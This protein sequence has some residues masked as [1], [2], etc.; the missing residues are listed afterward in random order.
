[1]LGVDFVI[2]ALFDTSGFRAAGDCASA[3]DI[4]TNKDPAQKKCVRFTRAIL[5]CVYQIRNSKAN[6]SS[7]DQL[8]CSHGPVGGALRTPLCSATAQ[9][10]PKRLRQRLLTRSFAL[11]QVFKQLLLQMPTRCF[12]DRTSLCCY[13]FFF[14]LAFSTCSWL[15]CVRHVPDLRPARADFSLFWFCVGI[16]DSNEVFD[17]GVRGHVRA[18]KAATCRRTPKI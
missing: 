4:P 8:S 18:F 12:F 1:M 17:F 10:A 3:I 14:H 15:G 9:Q 7:Y 6:R 5:V 16:H 13:A 2:S 11:V